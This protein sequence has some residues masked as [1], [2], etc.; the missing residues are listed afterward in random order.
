MWI[1]FVFNGIF[2][3]MKFDRI[4]FL[5]RQKLN[6]EYSQ[7]FMSMFQQWELDMQK[8]EEQGE[9]LTVSITTDFYNLLNLNLM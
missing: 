6:S 3:W 8:F 7:Q 9:K 5:Y 1:E 4:F 2:T